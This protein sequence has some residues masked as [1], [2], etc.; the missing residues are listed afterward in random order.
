MGPALALMIQY[1]TIDHLTPGLTGRCT[2]D[3]GA[4]TVEIQ[5]TKVQKSQSSG[6]TRSF[7]TGEVTRPTRVLKYSY[8][9]RINAKNIQK[10]LSPSDRGA[11][12]FQRGGYNPLAPPIFF[13]FFHFFSRSLPSHPSS[14]IFIW[15]FSFLSTS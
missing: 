15:S 14:L 3:E 7:P 11:S 12:M 2:M 5:P 9:G 8:W 4:Q 13:F 1:K 10:I 6:G